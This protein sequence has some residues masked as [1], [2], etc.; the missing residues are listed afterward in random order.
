[1]SKEV[2]EHFSL[3]IVNVDSINEN[4]K[5]IYPIECKT[6]DAVF[7]GLNHIPQKVMDMVNKDKCKVIFSYES[8]GDFPNED[9]NEWFYKSKFIF[10]RK[11]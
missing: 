10:K 3:T 11:N 2:K 8:E 9:F 5:Y 7:S 6:I 4:K 1:M